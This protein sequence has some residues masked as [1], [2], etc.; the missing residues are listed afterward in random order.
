MSEW[1]DFV[2]KYAKQKG[3][4]YGEA[5]KPAAKEW[6]KGK[7]KKGAVKVSATKS[8]KKGGDVQDYSS[9]KGDVRVEGG[10]RV[11][12]RR[13]FEDVPKSKGKKKN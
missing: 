7:G 10:H 5:L 12:G 2:K 1:T 11:K 8:A 9:K 6:A 13:A 4:K 3:L